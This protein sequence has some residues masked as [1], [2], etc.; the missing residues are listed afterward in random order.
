LSRR[1]VDRVAR[2]DPSLFEVWLW[3][4]RQNPYVSHRGFPG[5]NGSMEPVILSKSKLKNVKGAETVWRYALLNV[6]KWPRERP[7]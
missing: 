2:T 7:G 1:K 6:T 4:W 3:T 5:L